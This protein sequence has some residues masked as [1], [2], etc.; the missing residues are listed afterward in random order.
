MAVAASVALVVLYVAAGVAVGP[1]V[2]RDFDLIR[3]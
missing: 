3:S 1:S 2:R